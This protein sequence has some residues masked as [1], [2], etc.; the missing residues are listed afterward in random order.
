MINIVAFLF[1]NEAIYV[2]FKDDGTY[3]E[4]GNIPISKRMEFE[5]GLNCVDEVSLIKFDVPEDMD[6]AM[7]LYQKYC[8]GELRSDAFIGELLKIPLKQV[9]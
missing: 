6:D 3:R 1:P 2:R 7:N 4:V 8:V 5:Y 9:N